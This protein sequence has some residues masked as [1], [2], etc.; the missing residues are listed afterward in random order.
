MEVGPATEFDSLR[1]QYYS[2]YEYIILG[3]GFY[4]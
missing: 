1:A 3:L 2:I 4:V